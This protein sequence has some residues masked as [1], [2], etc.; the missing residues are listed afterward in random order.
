MKTLFE[1]KM[2][3]SD[4]L[5]TNPSAWNNLVSFW[6]KMTFPVLASVTNTILQT[7]SKYSPPGRNH[8]LGYATIP[9][10][11]YYC[12]IINI[13]AYIKQ[14]KRRR[15][16]VD[17]IKKHKFDRTPIPEELLKP[18]FKKQFRYV[19]LREYKR[20]G[21]QFSKVIDE[22]R[23]FSKPIK[24]IIQDEDIKLY[25]EDWAAWKNGM[26]FKIVSNKWKQRPHTIGY[27]STMKQAQKMARIVNR[28][29]AKYS[30]GSLL[31]NF[32]TGNQI[33]DNDKLIISNTSVMPHST[34]Q[35]LARKSP[36]ITKYTWGSI[37]IK[38]ADLK[39]LN[40]VLQGYTRNNADE[41][42]A[43]LALKKGMLAGAKKYKALLN[44]FAEQNTKSIQ[45]LMGDVF[46]SVIKKI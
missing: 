3:G 38:E 42:Y 46:R 13:D 28:G 21:K 6:K 31:K 1:S 41:P 14:T 36:N 44:A 16:L 19:K 26:K 17:F 18:R 22:V 23:E 15:S 5:R 43:R 11:M 2:T 33:L 34:F 35:T 20:H 9:E 40:W 24:N 7:A 10:D 39:N 45:R 25:K 27:A 30:W 29:L 8:T 12:R 37:N 4:I 32:G